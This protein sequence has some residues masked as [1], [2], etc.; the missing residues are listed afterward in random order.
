[1]FKNL[2]PRNLQSS[3]EDGGMLVVV[4]F[5]RRLCDR[6][7]TFPGKKIFKPTGKKNLKMI[8][9]IEICPVALSVKVIRICDLKDH[10]GTVKHRQEL[11][12]KLLN[13]FRVGYFYKG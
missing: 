7:P 11:T 10:F 9:G 13:L 8:S 1:M 2:L 12:V 3:D 4:C 5:S 6:L